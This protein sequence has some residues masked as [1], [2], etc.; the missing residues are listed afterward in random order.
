M[1]HTSNGAS[2]FLRSARMYVPDNRATW[3]GYTTAKRSF[4]NSASDVLIK[5]AWDSVLA[6]RDSIRR[7]TRT[8]N[9]WPRNKWMH[10]R[11]KS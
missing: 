5:S 7:Y 1:G 4:T 10:T 11:L 9:T 2:S 8:D 6:C 3:A